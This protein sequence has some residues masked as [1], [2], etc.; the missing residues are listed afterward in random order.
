MLLL[1]E[2]EVRDC[3]ANQ[4]FTFCRHENQ[5]ISD[6]FK[7]THG[8]HMELKMNIDRP[9]DIFPNRWN[10]TPVIT[11]KVIKANCEFFL[12]LIVYFYIIVLFILFKY[13]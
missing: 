6:N 12:Y 10:Q 13:V 3:A 5:R 11:E 4:R 7:N 8:N 1:S 9:I 2:R